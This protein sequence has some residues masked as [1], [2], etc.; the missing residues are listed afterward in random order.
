MLALKNAG[1]A[2]AGAM[3]QPYLEL[4]ETTFHAMQA[5]AVSFGFV[6]VY[7]KARPAGNTCNEG[8]G[9]GLED[10][11]SFMVEE[12]ELCRK[13]GCAER[14]YRARTYPA[15]PRYFSQCNALSEVLRAA[16]DYEAIVESGREHF[17]RARRAENRLPPGTLRLDRF[18]SGTGQSPPEIRGEGSTEA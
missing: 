3:P 10:L 6:F 14:E 12:M 13:E 9:I 2:F 15:L 18:I 5:G 1:F 11:R 7:Q 8:D 16:R 4:Y 17:G